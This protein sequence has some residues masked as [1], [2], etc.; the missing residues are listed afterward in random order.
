MIWQPRVARSGK[1]LPNARLVTASVHQEMDVPDHLHTLML[2]LMG[3]F[4]DHDMSKTA[5]AKIAVN[6]ER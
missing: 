5:I 2:M 4:V 3:Q 1:E 6:P